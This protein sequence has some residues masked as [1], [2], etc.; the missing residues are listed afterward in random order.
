MIDGVSEISRLET[1]AEFCERTTVHP[2][3]LSRG[4]SFASAEM[5][6]PVIDIFPVPLNETAEETVY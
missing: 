4:V 6:N 3:P 5:L 2:F 1:V